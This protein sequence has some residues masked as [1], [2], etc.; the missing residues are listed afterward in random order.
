MENQ[1][2]EIQEIQQKLNVMQDLET[3]R[4]KKIRDALCNDERIRLVR[5]Q[6]EANN[7]IILKAMTANDILNASEVNI[8]Q[9][10]VDELSIS[11][12]SHFKEIKELSDTLSRLI[13]NKKAKYTMRG[14]LG[15]QQQILNP[16]TEYNNLLEKYKKQIIDKL[17]N[18]L[19]TGLYDIPQNKIT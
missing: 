13:R 4:G 16:E 11:N 6:R 7:M 18:Q 10:V 1:D 2:R 14:I 9:E 15:Q 3:E 17:E 12:P 8:T 5:Q 19:K